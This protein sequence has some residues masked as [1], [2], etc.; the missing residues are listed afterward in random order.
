MFIL[1]FIKLYIK[2]AFFFLANRAMYRI[3]NAPYFI[4]YHILNELVFYILIENPYTYVFLLCAR[5]NIYFM[6]QLTTY[7]VGVLSVFIIPISSFIVTFIC[8]NSPVHYEILHSIFDPILYPLWDLLKATVIQILSLTYQ[9]YLVVDHL[10]DY[11]EDFAIYLNWKILSSLRYIPIDCTEQIAKAYHSNKIFTDIVLSFDL[12]KHRDKDIKEMLL[13]YNEDYRQRILDQVSKI[14]I[15]KHQDII[16]N[17]A[18]DLP[19]DH[20]FVCEIK[21]KLKDE[22]FG[23]ITFDQ[24]LKGDTRNQ[25]FYMCL[26]NIKNKDSVVT[27]PEAR[28][29]LTAYMEAQT[30]QAEELEAN[31]AIIEQTNYFENKRTYSF[32]FAKRVGFLFLCG[33]GIIGGVLGGFSLD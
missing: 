17:W 12:H 4:G 3:L 32:E 31:D 18:K 28:D 22:F 5:I 9:T 30:K 29:G 13:V 23:N 2:A 24:F 20:P 6:T 27:P 33:C 10:L 14:P 16:I 26:D 11:V 7:I 8:H 15:E 25:K 21:Q 1:S 19:E